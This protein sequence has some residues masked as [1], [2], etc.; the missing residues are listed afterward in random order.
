[1]EPA[2]LQCPCTGQYFKTVFNYDAPPECEIRFDFSSGGEYRREVL[3]CGLCGHFIS[4]HQMDMSRLYDGDY[5]SANYG[6]TGLTQNFERIISLDPAKSDNTGRVKRILDFAT[7]H[8]SRSE[9]RRTRSVLDIGSGLC[10]F[11]YRLKLSG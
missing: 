4:V 2:P 9:P 8:F 5:V 11:W 7:G 3:S 10:V 6:S 1:M